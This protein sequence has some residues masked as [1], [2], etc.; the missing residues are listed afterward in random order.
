[1]IPIKKGAAPKEYVQELEDY[2]RQTG[3]LPN[4]NREVRSKRAVIESL[5]FEQRGI[6]AYCMSRITVNNAHVEHILPQSKCHD[7]ED[8]SYDNMLAV[9]S[10]GDGAGKKGLHCDRARGD[11]ELQVN[12]LEPDTLAKIRYRHDGKILS[13]D[14][15]INNDIDQT[16]NLNG[17]F[18]HL[19]ENRKAVI[20]ELNRRLQRV[21]KQRGARAVGSYCKRELNKFQRNNAGDFPPYIGVL[22][23]FLERR[24]SR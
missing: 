22:M 21:A 15:D 9:C 4:W 8:L 16:L 14:P 5:V 7:G 19:V 3:E 13:E 20:D 24:A 12:P 17:E 23:Y 2:R 11:K 18:T 1:M 10:G 6:C